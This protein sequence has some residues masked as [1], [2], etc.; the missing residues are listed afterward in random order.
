MF[1]QGAMNSQLFLRFLKRLVK[2]SPRKI[3]LI[4]DNFPVHYSKPMKKW[5]A[6]HVN[7]I[8]LFFLPAFSPERKPDEYL[9]CD[10]KQSVASKVPAR[11][12]YQLV[13]QVVSHMK[14]IQKLPSHV[15]S[16][17]KNPNILYAI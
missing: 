16:Y 4:I 5:F 11:N 6:K 9:N 12:K 10:H 14:S 13:K 2:D 17:F 1:Y 15:I 7:E 8:E 3:C